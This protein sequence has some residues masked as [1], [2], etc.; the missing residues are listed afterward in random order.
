MP[1]AEPAPVPPI[2]SQEST[3]RS[4]DLADLGTEE[5]TI[6][7]RVV[8]RRC[9]RASRPGEIVVCAPDPEAERLGTISGA[10]DFEPSGNGPPRAAI[11][12]TENIE[13]DIHVDPYGLPNGMVSN[14]VMVG[15]K[16]AF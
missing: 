2:L 10:Q 5:N 6:D 16:V 1:L 12:L 11:K 8:Q 4:F 9:A 13:A 15:V 7:F 14:R 3:V